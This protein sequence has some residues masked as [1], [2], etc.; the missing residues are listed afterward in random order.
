MSL[1]L[2]LVCLFAAVLAVGLAAL[3]TALIPTIPGWLVEIVKL[4]A[5]LVAIF[6]LRAVFGI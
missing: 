1:L 6:W 3:L 5:L 4:A 2:A